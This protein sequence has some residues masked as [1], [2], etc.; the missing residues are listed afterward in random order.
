V[1]VVGGRAA[2]GASVSS[3]PPPD[4]QVTWP[5]ESDRRPIPGT[6]SVLRVKNEARSLPW[7][8]PPLLR[9]TQAVVLVDN[10]SDDGTP[11][12]ALQVARDHG[13]ADKLRVF[14]YPFDVSRCG[15]EHLGTPADSVHSLVHF[16]NWSF[17]HVETAYSLKWDGDMVLTEDAEGLIHDL[18]WQLPG[19][20]V[21]V[22]VPRHSLYVDDERVAYLDLGLPNVEAYGYPMGPAYTHVKAFEWELRAYPDDVEFVRLPDGAS[23]E[24]KW[25]DSDEFAHWTAPEAFADNFRTA[26]KRREYELFESLGRGEWERW[27]HLHRI[28]APEGVHVIDHVTHEWL[29]HADREVFSAHRLGVPEASQS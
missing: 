6:T 29:P 5:W 12:V 24:L 26:R 4:F 20:D 10:Q 14:H 16:Y 8:L 28:E 18:A 7:V 19:K 11:D 13:F 3:A 17:A 9:A 21:I 2:S 15:P 23:L 27:P 22:R 25:L 1:T